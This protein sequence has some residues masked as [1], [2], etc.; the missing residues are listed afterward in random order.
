MIQELG[1]LWTKE[2]RGGI[3]YVNFSVGLI[4]KTKTDF[5]I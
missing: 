3:D 1:Q 4:F 2:F 5:D